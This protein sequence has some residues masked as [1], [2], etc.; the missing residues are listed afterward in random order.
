[1]KSKRWMMWMTVGLVAAVAVGSGCKKKT[2]GNGPGEGAN[3]GGNMG[4]DSGE[5]RLAARPDMSVT[6]IPGQF[7]SVYF[8][9]DNSQIKESERA[10]VEVVAQQFKTSTASGVIVEG[11]CDERGSAEYNLALG[12]CRALAM[13]AYLMGLGLDTARIQTRSFGKEKPVAFGHDEEAWAKNRRAD[14]VLF[15]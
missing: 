3:I 9:F 6:E 12:E 4:T 8:D 1:M 5:G 13:R 15:K 10:K 11:N 7:A 2:A 14:F